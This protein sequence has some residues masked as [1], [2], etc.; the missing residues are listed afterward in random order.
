MQK[1]QAI[2]TWTVGRPGN[3]ASSSVVL[4]FGVVATKIKISVTDNGLNHVFMVFIE[5]S[6]GAEG[7][8]N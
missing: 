1:L 5:I 6:T 3:E 8:N 7:T 2:K 4:V